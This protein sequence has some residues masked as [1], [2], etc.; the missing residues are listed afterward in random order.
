[1]RNMGNSKVKETNTQD[2]ILYKFNASHDCAENTETDDNL[3][4]AHTKG[5]V[6]GHSN[7]VGVGQA[8]KLGVVDAV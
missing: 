6:E 5:Q 1:M 2:L 3:E 7:D 8:R 4:L